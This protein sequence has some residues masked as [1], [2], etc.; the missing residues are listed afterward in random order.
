MATD[1]KLPQ[2]INENGMIKY[3]VYDTAMAD[4]YYLFGM[5]MPSRHWQADSLDQYRFGFQG[6]RKGNQLYGDGNLY[7][8]PFRNYDPRLGRW[9]S[10]DPIQ[11][12]WQGSYTAFN[13]NPIYFV[14]PMG[15]EGDNKD[16]K[17]QK[18]Y[19]SGSK[20]HDGRISL[21]PVEVEAEREIPSGVGD[22]MAAEE[23]RHKMPDNP[24]IHKIDP[25]ITNDPDYSFTDRRIVLRRKNTTQD[26]TAG[27][28][29]ILRTDIEGFM[30]EPGGPPTQKQGTGRRIPP[31]RYNLKWNTGDDFPNAIRI[32]G[33]KVPKYR[34]ILIHKGAYP[35]HTDGCL[36]PG[37]SFAM[38]PTNEGAENA[39][40][41]VWNSSIKMKELR[42]FIKKVG[43][44]NVTIIIKGTKN[45]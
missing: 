37:C 29:E 18:I 15:L 6:M 36:M 45:Q 1:L 10:P 16:E 42:K 22:N 3:Y 4:D 30:L 41:A 35:R 38:N 19:G 14:D 28:F 24:P 5:Q 26:A 8:T 40:I 44:H 9:L 13:N 20:E 25:G 43:I 11:H 2:K 23:R 39:T 34:A 27:E 12:P 17:G 33:P 7:E 21:D 31:G 32:Y